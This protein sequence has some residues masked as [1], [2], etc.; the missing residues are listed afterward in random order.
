VIDRLDFL[1]ERAREARLREG[2]EKKTT[3]RKALAKKEP[4]E[5]KGSRK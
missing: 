5:G 2:T 1:T 4:P 3:D